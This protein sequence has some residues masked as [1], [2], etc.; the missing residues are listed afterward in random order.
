MRKYLRILIHYIGNLLRY[1]Q[2]IRYRLVGV[3][4]GK[5]TMISLDAKIDVHRGKVSIGD[6]SCCW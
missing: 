1:I 5:N 2:I 4:I 3:S 6:N